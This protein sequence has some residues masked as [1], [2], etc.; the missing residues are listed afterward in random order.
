[1]TVTL[2]NSPDLAGNPASLT[3]IPANWNIPQQ[4]TFGAT[5]DTI[6]EGPEVVPVTFISTSTDLRYHF[7]DSANVTITDNDSVPPPPVTPAVSISDAS[8]RS[9]KPLPAGSVQK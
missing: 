8:S 3:F 6:V 9:A 2:N 5:D 4:F 7:S 1:M